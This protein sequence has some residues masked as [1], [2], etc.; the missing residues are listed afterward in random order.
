MRVPYIVGRWVRG[1]NHY[2]R[3]PLL[4]HLLNTPDPAV[5]VVGA[6]RIGKTSLLR[7][8]EHLAEQPGST[9]AP[10]F[11]DMQGCANSGDLSSELFVAI[12]DE[13]ERFQGLGIVVTE[14][15]GHDAPVILRRMARAATAVQKT[16]LLL[17][18][19][20]EVLIKI[21]EQEPAWLERLRC[22]LDEGQMRTVLASTKLMAQL[23]QPPAGSG[24]RPFLTGFSLLNLWSLDAESAVELVQQRQTGSGIEVDP[25]LLENIIVNTNRHPYLIQYLCQRLY[26]EDAR[27][28]AS[29]RQP[30]S[31]ELEPDHL[32]S[33]F[34]LIDFQHMTILERR[35]LLKAA[36]QVVLGERE[37]ITAFP[38]VNP[39][40]IRIFLW[41]L[42]QLGHLRKVYDQWAIGNEFLRRWLAMKHATLAEIDA[43]P[44]DDD[45]Q[46]QLLRRS[47]R[48]EVEML[49][50]TIGRLETEYATLDLQ[51][52]PPEGVAPETHAAIEW[53]EK[54]LPELRRRL[55]QTLAAMPGP[56][57][58]TSTS[59]FGTNPSSDI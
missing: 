22:A 53:I 15:E 52:H 38:D 51:R 9:L 13:R 16:L 21:A 20:A 11:W 58:S 12:E 48:R 46:E 55:Q 24:Q 59:P 56:D 18:D 34:F 25:V 10:L 40:R 44:V 6:R 45:W 27:G 32:L 57:A 33:G 50:A 39:A 26:A 17:I 43:A 8:L 4:T 7:Q 42:G 2:G 36:E 49:R 28:Q 54:Q 3:Q 41:G 37:F 30:C 19:E 31:E 23:N 29:L 1:P 14:L 5:W 35:I 47:Q